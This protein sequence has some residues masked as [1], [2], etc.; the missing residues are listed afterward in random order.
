MNEVKENASDI[1]YSV[2][3][4]VCQSFRYKPSEKDNSN[5]FQIQ[6]LARTA[7]SQDVSVSVEICVSWFTTVKYYNS[8]HPSVHKQ[9]RKIKVYN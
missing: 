2:E 1:D 8:I 3:G 5:T 7:L 4:V 9:S 6:K